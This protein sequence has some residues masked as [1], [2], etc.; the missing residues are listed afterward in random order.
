MALAR[1]RSR[2]RTPTAM[3]S[4]M[5]LA[6]IAALFVAATTLTVARTADAC[7]ACFHGPT[8]GGVT[9]TTVVTGHRMAMAISQTQTVL[10][11]QI[12]YAGNPE[13]FAWVLP[14]KPGATLEVAQDAWFEMLDGGT[15]TAVF[16][17][18]VRCPPDVPPIGFNGCQSG[19]D[20]SASFD[21]GEPPPPSVTVVSQ[22]TVGPYETVTLS[23]E[24][25]GALGDWLDSHGYVIPDEMQPTIDAYVE[26]D[27]DFIALRLIPGN[28]VNMM[29]PVRVIMPAG[30]MTLP[31]RMVAGGT[32]ATTAINLFVIG[33]GRYE[34]QNVP[35]LL[36]DRSQVTWNYAT[37]DTNLNALRAL[38][39]EDSG[40]V[41]WLTS[42]ALPGTFASTRPDEA[43]AWGGATVTYRTPQG[44]AVNTLAELYEVLT[45]G[46]P[47]EAV[48]GSGMGLLPTEPCIAA[49]RTAFTKG[50]TVV[51]NCDEDGVCA[52]LGPDE[53]AKSE[54]VCDEGADDL[55]VAFTGMRMS[56]VWLTRLDA[57]LS[58][59]A[60]ESDLVLQAAAD[61]SELDSRF[62]AERYIAHPCGPVVTTA[63][64]IGTSSAPRLPGGVAVY[65][66]GGFGLALLWRRRS[67]DAS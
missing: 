63:S 27:F 47:P 17:K 52:D 64:V 23:T 16:S 21:G 67:L 8:A 45:S 19:G 61:Q 56:D 31:L 30:Q 60:F 55:A 59:A 14:V 41:G 51:D 35:N 7:G 12:E 4:V 34:V 32:G 58:R 10:W 38:A 18:P 39:F 22:G 2:D 29:Q 11:D 43:A 46:P 24:Q 37:N 54:L 13:E 66:L 44:W 50:L 57:E 5:R 49:I 62:T 42:Y 53:I 1:Q 40:G 15:A 3:L 65:L 28:G 33:E 9:E 48:S 25:P 36:I 6:C 20:A 26:E